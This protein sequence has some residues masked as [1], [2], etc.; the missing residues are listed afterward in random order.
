MDWHRAAK[1]QNVTYIGSDITRFLGM[2]LVNSFH[3]SA[4]ASVLPGRGKIVKSRPVR[5]YKRVGDYCFSVYLS[6][7]LHYNEH[8]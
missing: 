7:L 2:W 3:G 1:L 6:N 4:D 5:G 8:A